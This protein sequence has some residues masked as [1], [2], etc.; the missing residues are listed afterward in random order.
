[1]SHEIT[2][3]SATETDRF[4]NVAAIFMDLLSIALGYFVENQLKNASLENTLRLSSRWLEKEQ[5]KMTKSKTK[6][7]NFHI[8]KKQNEFSVSG[9]R[10]STGLL[11]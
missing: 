2:V 7:R 8:R 9:K 5:K 3:G 4:H 6:E 1:M 11:C 10:P